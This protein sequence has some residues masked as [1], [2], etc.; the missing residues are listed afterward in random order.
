MITQGIATATTSSGN[1]DVFTLQQE[2]DESGP[3]LWR[4]ITDDCLQMFVR[5]T[6]DHRVVPPQTWLTAQQLK[7]RR[8]RSSDEDGVAVKTP[9]TLH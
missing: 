2:V 8:V 7:E 3:Q 5:E 6:S 4:A 9:Q 1:L